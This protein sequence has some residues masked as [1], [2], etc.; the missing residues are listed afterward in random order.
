[1]ADGGIFLLD[2]VVKPCAHITDVVNGSWA[3]LCAG[4]KDGEAKAPGPKEAA[5]AK[6]KEALSKVGA[7]AKCGS[8]GG[9]GGSGK[10]LHGFKVGSLVYFE[11]VI[12]SSDA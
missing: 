3:K 5:L 12:T 1:M 4:T 6:S 9:G 11:M 2:V 8:A 7:A 10:V